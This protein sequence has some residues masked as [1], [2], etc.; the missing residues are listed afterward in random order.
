MDFGAGRT[1]ACGSLA[2]HPRSHS[3]TGSETARRRWPGQAPA[4]SAAIAG[5]ADILRLRLRVIPGARQS[6]LVGRHGDAWK[7]RVASPPEGGRANRAVLE[8]LAG[9]LGVATADV[10]VV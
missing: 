2:S 8:L 7:L 5:S 9:T 1:L 4:Y 3:E 6:A 10:R